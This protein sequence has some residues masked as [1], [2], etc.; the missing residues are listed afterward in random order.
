MHREYVLLSNTSSP[1]NAS[2]F[3]LPMLIET[4]IVQVV[5]GSVGFGT[6]VLALVVLFCINCK[7][8]AGILYSIRYCKYLLWKR[9]LRRQLL[10]PVFHSQESVAEEFTNWTQET[11]EEQ[12][13]L[14]QPVKQPTSSFRFSEQKLLHMWLVVLCFVNIF[15]ETILYLLIPYLPMDVNMPVPV[16]SYED[17]L[18]KFWLGVFSPRIITL[19]FTSFIYS[20]IGVWFG[21]TYVSAKLAAWQR[22][23]KV[24]TVR[25]TILRLPNTL[26]VPLYF[27]FNVGFTILI[28]STSLIYISNLYYSEFL[29]LL[30]YS[31]YVGFLCFETICFAVIFTVLVAYLTK[32]IQFD[33][34]T[35]IIVRRMKRVLPVLII[36]IILYL[37]CFTLWS[38]AF[39][40]VICLR[41]RFPFQPTPSNDRCVALFPSGLYSSS[42]KNNLTV[43]VMVWYLVFHWLPLFLILI[44]FWP[45]RLDQKKKTLFMTPVL[46]DANN[47]RATSSI[48]SVE[49]AGGEVYESFSESEDVISYSKT[50]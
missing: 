8:L 35:V 7:V 4:R 6:I 46:N 19:L 27:V 3:T 16:I 38:I 41:L 32:N 29:R 10:H 42:V 33:P 47:M 37:F 30:F 15:Q 36:L 43:E 22:R 21:K 28:L 9:R 14:F 2:N 25:S 48:N 18:F 5:I 39:Y 11:K 23:Q 20:S 45:I 40:P 50:T 1:S 12:K 13:L 34:E 24:K 17:I 31:I 26:I 49:D 44:I